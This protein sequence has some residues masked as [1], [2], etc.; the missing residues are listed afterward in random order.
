MNKFFQAIFGLATMFAFLFLLHGKGLP[1]PAP[2]VKDT[3]TDALFQPILAAM[4]GIVGYFINALIF[5]LL[6]SLATRLVYFLVEVFILG[7]HLDTREE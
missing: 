4:W 7:R 5:G 2:D 1:R 6:V 3:V